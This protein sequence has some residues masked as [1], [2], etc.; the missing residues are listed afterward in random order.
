MG[1]SLLKPPKS[2]CR[3]RAK[4]QKEDGVDG[5]KFEKQDVVER[6][7]GIVFWLSRKE[8]GILSGVVYY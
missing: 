6:K 4:S 7:D 3:R 1:S 5:P 2:R 8:I